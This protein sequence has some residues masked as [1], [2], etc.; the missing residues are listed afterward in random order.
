MTFRRI[1]LVISG[2]TL[3]AVESAGMLF[4]RAQ[5]LSSDACS[6]PPTPATLS[7][8][9]LR[10]RHH[11]L[12]RRTMGPS[13]DH[14]RHFARGARVGPRPHHGRTL[15][16]L[17]A[18][19]LPRRPAQGSRN[20]SKSTIPARARQHPPGLRLRARP[21]HH[22]EI[23]RQQRRDRRHL[24]EI[25]SKLRTAPP[26]SSMQ[27]SRR[28]GRMGNPPR[29]RRRHGQSRRKK[30]CTPNGGNSALPARRKST[31]PS[32]PKPNSNILYDK[33]YEDNKKVRVAGPFTVESLSP[34]RVLGV[35]ENDE[36]IDWQ[37]SNKA[38]AKTSSR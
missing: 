2:K 34:H 37:S 1:P 3:V 24:G 25:P 4:R 20:H 6:W 31:P 10:L 17:P 21:A 22:A 26:S 27:R 12:R 35:D 30:P 28:M 7:S 9:H 32:P 5:G 36:L 8:T 33:P 19:R 18:R 23:H 29:G 38:E 11:R 16:V 15:S 13:L 14:H